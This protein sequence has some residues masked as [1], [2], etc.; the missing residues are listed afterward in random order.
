MAAASLVQSSEL[1]HLH[2]HALRPRPAAFAPSGASQAY[3][4][5]V[6]GKGGVS[7]GTIESAFNLAATEGASEMSAMMS[8]QYYLAAA[9]GWVGV[10]KAR[11]YRW[12]C[13]LRS[14]DAQGTC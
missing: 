4:L 1:S 14:L 5:V 11:C 8:D 9:H 7:G 3:T 13:T 2:G 12:A 10:V 6:P